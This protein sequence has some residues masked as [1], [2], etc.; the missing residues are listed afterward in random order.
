MFEEATR[1][2][3]RKIKK[4]D[5]LNT[6]PPQDYEAVNTE[7][8]RLRDEMDMMS[9]VLEALS[10]YEYGGAVMKNVKNITNKISS[11]TSINMLKSSDIYT[12][13]A[14]V[15]DELANT[16]HNSSI[17]AIGNKYS[18]AYLKISECKKQMNSK[19]KDILGSLKVL[20][21]EAKTIDSLRRKS[22]D[23]RYDLEEKI[24]GDGSKREID[25]LQT[26]FDSKSL[27]A[28]RGMKTFIGEAGIAGLLKRAASA[29]QGFTEAAY[30]ALSNVQ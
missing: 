25:A 2:V 6:Q 21:D 18:E 16:T 26:E 20:R 28:L 14:T 23:L 9:A 24:Q 27:D 5:Y 17:K 11:G 4:I 10:N 13:A 22:S 7:Y 8:R 15:G 19:V 3:T 30:K 29:H 12:Q 1:Y